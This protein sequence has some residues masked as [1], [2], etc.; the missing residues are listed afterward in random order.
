MPP[1]VTVWR[2]VE[3]HSPQWHLRWQEADVFVM[4][5]TNEAFGLVYQEAAA[6]GLPAIGT[7]LNAVPEIIRDGETGLLVPPGD[8]SALA[9]AMHAL[10]GS[11]EWR[12]RMGLRARQL[13]E[14]AASPER[15]LERLTA[16][17]TEAAR[18]RIL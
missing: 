15:Y 9:S 13:I 10:I 5:T 14:T 3:A 1:G 2:D 8:V 17:I 11:T 7:R 16:I 6:A 4:P 12:H 18:S